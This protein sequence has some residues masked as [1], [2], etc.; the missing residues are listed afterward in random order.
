MEPRCLS[1]PSAQRS[2]RCCVVLELLL[3][4]VVASYEQPK[5]SPLFMVEKLASEQGG[6]LYLGAVSLDSQR[7]SLVVMGE[8]L[9]IGREQAGGD[10]RISKQH[11]IVWQD[12]GCFWLKSLRCGAP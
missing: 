9:V 8:E 7:S 4:K 2:P 6:A 1:P 3:S 12:S 5:S 10:G 11:C